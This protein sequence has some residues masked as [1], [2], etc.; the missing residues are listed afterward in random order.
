MHGHAPSETSGG[1]GKSSKRPLSHAANQASGA[2]AGAVGY[3]YDEVPL[4]P[5]PL[6]Y[7]VGEV[8]SEV[9]SA[10]WHWHVGLHAFIRD[11]PPSLVVLSY[12][13]VGRRSAQA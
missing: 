3:S 13:C 9:F 6:K 8:S 5:V 4:Q 11:H 10:A 7:V 1:R 2:A 12:H